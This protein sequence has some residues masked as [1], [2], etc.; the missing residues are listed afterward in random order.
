MRTQRHILFTAAFITL[1]ATL[2]PPS[3][4]ADEI[5]LTSGKSLTGLIIGERNGMYVVLGDA[6]L[7]TVFQSSVEKVTIDPETRPDASA[8]SKSNPPSRLPSWRG[9]LMKLSETSWADPIL[10]IPATVITNGV[11]RNVPY[12]SFSCGMGWEMNI[13]GDLEHPCALELGASAKGRLLSSSGK[14]DYGQSKALDF[15]KQVFT[16]SAEIQVLD[17]LGNEET[18]RVANGLTFEVTP[19]TADDAEGGWWLSIYEA[20]AT[21]NARATDAE[22][23]ELTTPNRAPVA[24]EGKVTAAL[25][26]PPPQQITTVFPAASPTVSHSPVSDSAYRDS[27]PSY[28]AAPHASSSYGGSVYVHGYTKR[29]GT[30]VAPHTRSGPRR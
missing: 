15:M 11:F 6:Q 25:A 9:V 5:H 16:N 2:L 26:P 8:T 13:Y 30:Y 17:K 24:S 23:A 7:T 28:F 12:V 21:D 19:P 1:V 18:K 4:L 20:A 22:L 14:L 29:N 10:F 3:S 27:S